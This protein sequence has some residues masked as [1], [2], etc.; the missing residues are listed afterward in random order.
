MNIIKDM[1]PAEKLG[2]GR[3]F[4][5]KMLVSE[6]KNSQWGE[7]Q[8]KNAENLSLDPAAKSLH[9]AQEIFE[10]L[11]AYKQKNGSFVLFR[12]EA[13]VSRM[14]FSAEV[15]AMPPFPEDIFNEG[16]I[17][18]V[19]ESLAFVPEAPGSLYL[20]PTM[21]STTPHLGVAP[22][23]DYLFYVLAG[24]VG[25]Y[26]EGSN[27]LE[28]SKISIQATNKY[29]RAVRGG[30]GAAKTGGNY[31]ASL[32]AIKEAK[33]IG[34]TNVLF[35]DA[36]NRRNL[37]ELGGMNIFAVFNGEL[38]TPKLADTILAGV[39]RDSILKLA[40]TLGIKTI[41]RDITIDEVI[42]GSKSGKT[43][44]VF[45]CGTAAVIASVTEIGWQNEKFP[46]SDKQVGPVTQ[47]LYD[48]LVGI[49]YGLKSS[50]FNDWIRKI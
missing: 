12:P 29:V 47:K 48:E 10:G 15:M 46:I 11:K 26:F 14:S 38:H 16:L 35:L 17:R 13:N 2:F 27:S 44:E 9:Y 19:K 36:I 3:Y 45:A 37:E 32:R 50:P 24:P 42:E 5:P 1:L 7:L 23:N 6:Y 34:Y 4:C 18:L 43:Q 49:Q 25:G 39:T 20:R 8:L 33:A 31:A 30:I 22:G 40:K 41:E 21:I 28:I